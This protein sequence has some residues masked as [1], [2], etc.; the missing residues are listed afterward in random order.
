MVLRLRAGVS[1]PT[2]THGVGSQLY[3]CNVVF[4]YL[5]IGE[6]SQRSA[7]DALRLQGLLA[8]IRN[9]DAKPPIGTDRTGD[10]LWTYLLLILQT[11]GCNRPHLSD[12][13]PSHRSALWE[14]I[15]VEPN[16][17]CRNSTV[18]WLAIMAQDEFFPSGGSMARLLWVQPSVKHCISGHA[19]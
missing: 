9:I 10:I 17:L 18:Y 12:K 7:R 13:S 6:T 4:W 19:L 5:T 11:R 15:S 1:Y 2:L 3:N 16:C 14:S 8:R